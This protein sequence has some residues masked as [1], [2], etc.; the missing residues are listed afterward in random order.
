MEIFLQILNVL[1]LVGLCIIVLLAKNYFPSYLSKKASNIATKEDIGEITNKVE[2]IKV[3]YQIELEKIRA[4]ID[5]IKS[6]KKEYTSAQRNCLLQ[7]YD[8]SVELLVE[9]LSINFG[10][11]PMDEGQSMVE[12]QNSFLSSTSEMLKALQRLVLYFDDDLPIRK[13]A[14]E[15]VTDALRARQVLKKH[16]G[17][18]KLS[19]VRESQ[20]WKSN[21]R[22]QI[23]AAVEEA[24]KANKEYWDAM[25]PIA[26]RCA[27]KMA[28]FTKQ[29][30][31]YLKPN[32]TDSISSMF[33]VDKENIS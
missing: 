25:K 24:N 5:E 33:E 28:E 2:G 15:I 26:N 17:K 16:F 29:L 4:S 3:S 13:A 7:L 19:H 22:K 20:A 32:E 18:V 23:D 11:F 14:A 8:L 21:D 9:K 27:G 1:V 12:F 31:A 10:D 30:N 6:E